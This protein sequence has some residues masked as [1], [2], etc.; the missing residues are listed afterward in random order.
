MPLK[1][2]TVYRISCD[3]SDVVYVGSTM[4]SIDKRLREHI[5]D[6]R[7]WAAGSAKRSCSIF[8][9]IVE[10]GAE[11]FKIEVIKLYRVADARHLRVYETLWIKRTPNVCNH[12]E[13]FQIRRLWMRRNYARNREQMLK[14]QREHYQANR[15]QINEQQRAR[16]QA[17]REQ[18]SEYQRKYRQANREQ[19]LRQQ[20]RYRQANREQINARQREYRRANHA[21][22]SERQRDYVERHREQINA[23]GRTRHECACGR[24]YTH[25]NQSRHM[26]S[27][28]HL[29]WA[30]EQ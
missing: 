4:R 18:I 6:S 14:R 22:V 19:V 9:H 8:P 1:L 15:D 11:H 2:G 30:A 13:P 24:H 27:K 7:A 21:Q 29:R 16:Y 20:R 5:S 23:R 10:H 25:N 28:K 3:V 12:N 26:N 17:N